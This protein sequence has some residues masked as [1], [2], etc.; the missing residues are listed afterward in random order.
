MKWLTTKN[1]DR[2]EVCLHKYDIT[3]EYRYFSLLNEMV[4]DARKNT[5]QFMYDIQ[6]GIYFMALLIRHSKIILN[7]SAPVTFIE[8]IKFIAKFLLFPVMFRLARLETSRLK[9]YA[10][11]LSLTCN[12]VTVNQIQRK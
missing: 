12:K 7:S 1:S 5:K 8:L 9:D 10:Q 11:H 2:C 6:L 4:T 3:V